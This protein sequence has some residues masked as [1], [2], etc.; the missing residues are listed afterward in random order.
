MEGE[1]EGGRG[2]GG[3]GEG[4]E[5]RGCTEGV[6]RLF[7]GSFRLTGSCVCHSFPVDID[8]GSDEDFCNAATLVSSLWL[9]AQLCGVFV[10][11][12]CINLRS[13]EP[14]KCVYTGKQPKHRLVPIQL[15]AAL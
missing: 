7:L 8:Q 10:V 5:G 15:D 6:I 9:A 2:G 4:R 13:K 14:Q 12:H 3:G 11:K 1:E